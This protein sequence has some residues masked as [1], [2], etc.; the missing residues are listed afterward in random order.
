MKVI[1]FILVP[2]FVLGCAS[3]EKVEVKNPLAYLNGETY[4][5][6][7][8]APAGQA[9]G[10]WK[11]V[12]GIPVAGARNQVT[13]VQG[14][15]MTGE[16]INSTPLKFTK[17]RLIDEDRKTVAEASTDINGNFVLS[18]VIT[19]GHYIAKVVSAKFLGETEVFVDRYSVDIVIRVV[20]IK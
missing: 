4:G 13:R 11:G 1:G 2:L 15:V 17:V 16:G 7:G 14:V 20:A 12:S 19:N 3:K 5:V 8:E 18:G 6:K 10:V 9:E